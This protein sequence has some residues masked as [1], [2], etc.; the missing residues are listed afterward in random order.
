MRTQ[1]EIVKRMTEVTAE[2][3]FGF[4]QEVLI[5]ALEFERAKPFLVPEATAEKWQPWNDESLKAA[6]LDY[7]EFAWGKAEDHR[8]LSAERSVMKLT[9]YAW[10]MGLTVKDVPY[11]QYGCPFLKAFSEAIGA[12][13]PDSIPLHRMM[14]GEPCREGCDMGCGA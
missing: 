9:E 12:P 6:A 14:R 3:I 5:G 7:L 4:Q 1:D 8:G 11:A 13:V 2:D 10:L